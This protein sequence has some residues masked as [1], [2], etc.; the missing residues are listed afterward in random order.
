MTNLCQIVIQNKGQIGF[1]AAK[2]DYMQCFGIQ[3]T[4]RIVNQLNIGFAGESFANLASYLLSGEHGIADPYLC[5]ADY[6]SY[7]TTHAQ[8]IRDYAD[9]QKWNR[10]SLLNIAASGHF[11]ADRSIEEYAQRIWNLQKMPKRS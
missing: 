4:Y 5:L 10:M 11:A 1:P 7:R 2:V 8:M 6:E 9:K 3:I